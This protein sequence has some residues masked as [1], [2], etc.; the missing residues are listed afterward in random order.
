MI[1]LNHKEK[2]NLIAYVINETHES[3]YLAG[4][5]WY[6]FFFRKI[7]KRFRMLFAE[8]EK[9]SCCQVFILGYSESANIFIVDSLSL[10]GED[11]LHEINGDRLVIRQIVAAV[12]RQQTKRTC[13]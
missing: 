2:V 7:F 8:L 9:F 10:S 6:V 3:A 12:N 4:Q 1:H 5:R 13:N 11:Q